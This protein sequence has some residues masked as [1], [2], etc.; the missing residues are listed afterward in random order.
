MLNAA[1]RCP[2]PRFPLRAAELRSHGGYIVSTTLPRKE[3]GRARTDDVTRFP[4]G[5]PLTCSS[6]VIPLLLTEDHSRHCFLQTAWELESQVL[7]PPTLCRMHLHPFSHTPGS[8]IWWRSLM[9]LPNTLSTVIRKSNNPF[10]LLDARITQHAP[11]I[12]LYV[13][14]RIS[15]TVSVNR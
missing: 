3:R 8:R 4:P 15:P 5:H 10:V 12:S 13:M 2:T 9:I 11:Y 6:R 7:H 1:A 14:S